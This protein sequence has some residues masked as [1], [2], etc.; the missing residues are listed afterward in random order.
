MII[1]PEKRAVA[2]ATRKT[3]RELSNLS[4]NNPDDYAI[5]NGWFKIWDCGKYVLEY[6]KQ[7]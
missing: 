1:T 4:N 7:T 6:K 2:R 5:N 3:K